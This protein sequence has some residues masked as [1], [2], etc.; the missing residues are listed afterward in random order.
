MNARLQG[1]EAAHDYFEN[2]SKPNTWF[3][4]L[5]RERTMTTTKYIA[6]I[7]A[8]L[9]STTSFA[10]GELAFERKLAAANS[11]DVKATYDVGYRYEKGRGVDGDDELAFEWYSKA[12]DRG[13][14]IAQ[15]KVGRFYLKG[16]GVDK[17]IADAEDWLA[18]AADQGYPPAQ[19][20]LGKLYA[21]KQKRKYKLA[22]NWLQKAR[23]N[24]YEPATREIRKVKKKLN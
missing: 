2:C 8:L 22:L 23:D 18:K 15:Y 1:L 6:I 14:D 9:A 3:Q 10:A 7:F 11:G 20:Q 12:A 24:G 17:S 21:S 5:E 19:F 4:N 16:Q 13:L